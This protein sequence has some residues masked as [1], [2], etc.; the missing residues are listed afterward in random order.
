MAQKMKIGADAE[1][2][3]EGVDILANAVKVMARRS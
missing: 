1:A 3:G 2:D